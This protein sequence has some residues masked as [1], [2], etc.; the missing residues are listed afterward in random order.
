MKYL[1]LALALLL[2][3]GVVYVKSGYCAWCLSS[4]CMTSSICGSGCFC[5]KEGNKISGT[6]VSVGVRE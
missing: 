1:L 2:T 3:L 5:L 6:C 4:T